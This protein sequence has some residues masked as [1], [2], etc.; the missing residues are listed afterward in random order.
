MIALDGVTTGTLIDR[1][2]RT[3]TRA[4]AFEAEDHRPGH[5]RTERESSV[6]AK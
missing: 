1:A 4:I 6:G 3:R 2:A 5:D